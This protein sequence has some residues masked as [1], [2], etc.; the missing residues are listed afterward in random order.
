MNDDLLFVSKSKRK[1]LGHVGTLSFADRRLK[2][3][4]LRELYPDVTC[5][6]SND[7][8]RFNESILVSHLA[9]RS[10][11]PRF[12]IGMQKAVAIHYHRSE[13]FMWYQ[14]GEPFISNVAILMI[15][16]VDQYFYIHERLD[17]DAN[18]LFLKV[19]L[20]LAREYIEELEA[21]ISKH[22]LDLPVHVD[23]FDN[24]EK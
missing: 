18:V 22:G 23:F 12:E 21:N 14:L 3:D 1:T 6:T 13:D 9:F 8:H 10:S 20:C 16:K 5:M 17:T 24:I 11:Q 15:K 7:W 2:L 19:N 4:H